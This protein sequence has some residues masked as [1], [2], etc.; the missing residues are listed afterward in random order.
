MTEEDLLNEDTKT[1]QLILTASRKILVEGQR[2]LAE[3]ADI[4][5]IGS[6]SFLFL[7]NL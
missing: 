4:A 6:Y 3:K 5:Q 2:F 7:N 1:I